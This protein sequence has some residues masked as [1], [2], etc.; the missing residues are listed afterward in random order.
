MKVGE[1]ILY[2]GKKRSRSILR[3]D[4]PPASSPGFAAYLENIVKTSGTLA[5]A[6]QRLGYRSPTTIRYHMRRL[7]I[8]APEEWHRRPNLAVVMRKMCLRLSSPPQREGHG[9]PLSS[10][11]RDVFRAVTPRRAIRLTWLWTCQWSIPPPSFG[12]QSTLDLGRRLSRLRITSGSHYGI[13]IS[14]ASE[15]FE[16]CMRFYPFWKGRNGGK[17]RKR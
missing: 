7:G 12:S 14:P 17:P 8:K 15:P 3:K 13:R 2:A 6:V 10:R 9:S 1:P 11:V 16:F 4:G 5:E